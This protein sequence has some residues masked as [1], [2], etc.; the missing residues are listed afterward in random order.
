M[1]I[2]LISKRKDIIKKKRIQHI[3]HTKLSLQSLKLL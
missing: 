3:L 2:N 1:K